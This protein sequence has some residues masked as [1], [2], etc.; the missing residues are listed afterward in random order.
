[1]KS[2]IQEF[3]K[4]RRFAVVGVSR[5]K[6]KFG[7]TIYR[8]L[9]D[10]GYV[11]YGVNP[12]MEEIEGDRCFHSVSELRNRVDAVVLC[13]NPDHVEPVLRDAAGAGVKQIWLQQ[14][15]QSRQAID[16][17]KNLGLNVIG[18]KCILMYAEPVHSFH[19]FHR[20]LVRLIGR[21]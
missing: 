6:K 12:S 2:E 11:V 18:G 17:G 8:E 5:D 14:G 15:A 9:K 4:S 7:N 19:G 16:A 21:Y 20:F 10:R 13:L 3:V 1:M